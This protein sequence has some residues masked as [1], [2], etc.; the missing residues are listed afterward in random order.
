MNRFYLFLIVLSF[1]T[2]SMFAQT[3][4]VR[5][6]ETNK[7][8]MENVQKG[9]DQKDSKLLYKDM[10]RALVSSS[11]NDEQ[12][13]LSDELAKDRH[14]KDSYL[15]I[16]NK[17]IINEANAKVK[18]TYEIVSGA[19][20][21]SEGKRY[22][23]NQ[24][25]T[26]KGAKSINTYKSVNDVKCI[27][28]NNESKYSITIYWNV[29]KD[30]A[31]VKISHIKKAKID[32]LSSE[33]AKM[34]VTAETL[35]KDWYKG[36]LSSYFKDKIGNDEMK[37]FK[38]I[39]ETGKDVD[40]EQIVVKC[41]N[42]KNNE[43]KIIGNNLPDVKV[44]VDPKKYMNPNTNIEDYDDPEA[45]YTFSEPTFT[46]KFKDDFKDA[47]LSVDFNKKKEPKQLEPREVVA[48]K[49]ANATYDLANLTVDFT[50]KLKAYLENPSDK[51]AK[52]ELM[53]LFD[54]KCKIEVAIV[55]KT[56][57]IKTESRT[58]DKYLTGVNGTNIKI[59]SVG[60]PEFIDK[61]DP[62]RATIAFTQK[63]VNDKKNYCDTTDKIMV[64][65]KND[66][67][68]YKITSIKVAEDE[69]TK[70]KK[71]SRCE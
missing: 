2:L 56:G 42:P 30:S 7:K 4:N 48:E 64:I 51:K 24:Q 16:V 20:L 69:N 28:N 41:D 67:G 8:F 55:S 14:G 3:E 11:K 60:T 54:E 9:L 33:S 53:S 29:I 50:S 23:K 61:N 65:Q 37:S 49:K 71:V 45:F 26:K 57:K 18:F 40:A 52:E 27:F 1:S 17:G 58:T 46:V 68:D 22:D 38:L 36:K 47:D 32:Y 19:Q 15:E 62:D 66:N 63:H 34:K 35:V 10:I 31:K 12:F 5:V 25:E 70:A 6:K 44:Y 43:V 39:D 13:L 59:E 21:V